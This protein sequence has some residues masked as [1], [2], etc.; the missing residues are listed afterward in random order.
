MEFTVTPIHADRV[1][2]TDSTATAVGSRALDHLS[3]SDIND[4]GYSE[5][6]AVML[7][8]RDVFTSRTERSDIQSTARDWFN[9]ISAR[10]ADWLAPYVVKFARDHGL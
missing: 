3:Y 9:L 10:K 4:L 8:C 5:R 6:D 2:V 1:A 7:A